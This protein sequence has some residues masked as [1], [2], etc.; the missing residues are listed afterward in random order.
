[1][2]A[3]SLPYGC[4]REPIRQLVEAITGVDLTTPERTYSI[5]MKFRIDGRPA[6]LVAADVWKMAIIDCVLG[7]RYGNAVSVP[8]TWR[9][10]PQSYFDAMLGDKL[11]DAKIEWPWKT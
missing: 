1:M 7:H 5:G 8:G 11:K 10:L 6:I 2:N 3:L 9:N 4:D